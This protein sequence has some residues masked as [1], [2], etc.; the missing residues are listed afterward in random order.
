MVWH[1]SR[2]N[3]YHMC[4]VSWDRRQSF[5]TVYRH[6]V[7]PNPKRGNAKSVNP[8]SKIAQM[9]QTHLTITVTCKIIFYEFLNITNLHNRQKVWCSYNNYRPIHTFSF[10]QMTNRSIGWQR[11]FLL[12]SEV[13]NAG[14]TASLPRGNSRGNTLCRQKRQAGRLQGVES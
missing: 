6:S 2:L 4:H 9:S 14:N 7:W 3:M 10:L 13:R 8:S 1:L 12:R 5:F 11:Y